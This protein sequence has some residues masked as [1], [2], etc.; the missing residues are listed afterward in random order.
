MH[1]LAVC[2]ALL[3]QVLD[4]SACRGRRQVGRVSLRIGPLSG[5]EPALLRSAFPLAAARSACADAQLL[6]EESAIEVVCRA[7]RSASTAVANHILCA[8]CGS[9]RVEVTKGDE[10][11]LV[12]IELLDEPL[13]CGE[14]LGH[15]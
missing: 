2:Q 11:L 8:R 13:S 6:I 4:I 7:C 10:L 15:V 9:W 3:R 5:V 12:E 14:A 1:E